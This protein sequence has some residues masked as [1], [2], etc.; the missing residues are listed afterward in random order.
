MAAGGLSLA[1]RLRRRTTYVTQPRGV[2]ALL[3]LITVMLVLGPL[4]VLVHTSI[5][6]QGALP[7]TAEP[8]TLDNY[9]AAFGR[10]DTY[11]LV[12]NT[13]WYAG[14][15]VLLAV[16]LA[17]A[18]AWLAERTDLPV[19]GAVHTLMFSWMAV[20]PLVMAFG[21]ILLLNPNNGAL[22][23]A[24]KAVFGLRESPITIYSIWAMIAITGISLVP[25][26]YVMVSNILRNMDTQLESAATASG[27]NRLTVLRRITLPL[28]SPGLLSVAIYMFMVMVQAFD[29]PLAIGLTARTP[30]LSTRIYVLTA[31]NE[32]LPE[33]G[34][35]AA[36]GTVLM[37][38]AIGL[39]WGYFRLVRTGERFRVVTGK[40]FRPRRQRLGR[41]KPV[42]GGLV[43][44][45]FAMMFLPL[46]M[47]LW[48]SL[49]PFYRTPT[50]E[51]LSAVTLA[52]YRDVLSQ[53]V[54]RQA[55]ANTVLLALA[56]ATLA[57]GLAGLISW[58]SVRTSWR[59]ARWLETLAFMPT[60]VPHIVMAM[61][62]MVLYL[63]TPL[64]GTVALL[65]LA[66]AG[67]YIAFGTRTMNSAL[68]QI[69][70]ELENA[71]TVSGAPWATTLRRIVLPILWPQFLNG[72]LWVVAHSARD[73]TVPLM[74]MSTG[75]LVVSSL[76][77]MMWE[78]P[79]VPS[80]AALAVLLVVAL[81]SLVFVVQHFGLK[82]MERHE[83]AG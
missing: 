37:V 74:L 2:L 43:L 10:A 62:I 30:V 60:A 26:T 49:L 82:R 33:Y 28:L 81:M 38:F 75:N 54:V 55:A 47:L 16:A 44:L 48:T 71:A 29:V 39:M 65:I 8:T 42:M 17:T 5:L 24:L 25:T 20:P 13:L 3:A 77:W 19:R 11:I 9:R 4:I 63:R 72:W 41:L 53:P 22:N 68:L 35:S 21:W 78:H 61:A 52:N 23:I 70:Q 31:G 15:S 14:G 50:V 57:M 83:P 36:L 46:L 32:A 64:H 80:A 18:I 1:G 58:Y 73:L 66:H 51:A 67:I 7:L 76:L 27:A 6:P 45:Y 59:L 79:N 40:A 56:S 69:H 12:R 34:L